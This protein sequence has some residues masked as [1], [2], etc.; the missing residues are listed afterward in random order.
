MRNK[1]LLSVVVTI[2]VAFGGY[3]AFAESSGTASGSSV[4]DRTEACKRAKDQAHAM[5]MMRKVKEVGSCDCSQ[6]S[7]K[8]WN[9]IVDY[10]CEY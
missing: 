2:V 10:R 6:D 3:K 1:W 7:T 9:C 8:S 5:C 4:F